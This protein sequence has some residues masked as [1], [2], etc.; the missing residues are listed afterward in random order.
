MGQPLFPMPLLD[1]SVII[2]DALFQVFNSDKKVAAHD[3]VE[4]RQVLESA[5]PVG[6]PPLSEQQLVLFIPV[7]APAIEQ[8]VKRVSLGEVPPIEEAQPIPL[9]PERRCESFAV[10]VGPA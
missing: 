9:E 1:L 5:V 7:D 6:T 8:L 4:R 2:E 10:E 3:D